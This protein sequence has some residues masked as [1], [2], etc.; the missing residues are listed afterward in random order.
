[1]PSVANGVS[2]IESTDK[3]AVVFSD[4]LAAEAEEELVVEDNLDVWL[5]EI[6][7]LSLLFVSFMNSSQYVQ[8]P[9]SG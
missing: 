4:V 1:M 2:K 7:R 5:F 9:P 8:R 6:F 3:I